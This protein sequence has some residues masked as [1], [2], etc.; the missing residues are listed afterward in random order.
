MRKP[1]VNLP[2]AEADAI[3]LGYL[4]D[5]LLDSSAR[6][7]Q[8][9]NPA[10]IRGFSIEKRL[11]ATYA[12]FFTH[13]AHLDGYVDTSNWD[14]GILNCYPRLLALVEPHFHSF[15]F[16]GEERWAVMNHAGQPLGS[17]TNSSQRHED[18]LA[19]AMRR[20][21]LHQLCLVLAQD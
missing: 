1:L 20:W 17:D 19:V 13:P 2:S 21:K 16:E 6:L 18:A 7:V 3:L 12:Y 15:M 14:F 4:H 8:E 5:R 9:T 11:I 10:M